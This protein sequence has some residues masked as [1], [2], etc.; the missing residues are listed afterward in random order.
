MSEYSIKIPRTSKVVVDWRVN[1]YEY[2]NDAK[3]EMIGKISE[4]YGI[5]RR[6]IKL[7]P[8]LIDNDNK[9]IGITSDIISNIQKPQFQVSLFEQYIKENGITDANFDLI[10]EIDSEINNHIDYK[11]YDNYCN[12][13]INW[14]KWSN[15]LSYGKD[16]FFDFRTLKGLV[17][18]SGKPGNQSGKSTFAI[19]LIH[20]LLFGKTKKAKNLSQVFNS[21]LTDETEC[22]VEGSLTIEGQEYIIRRVLTRPSSTRRTSKSKVTQKVTY[23]RVVGDSMEELEDVDVLN[24]ENNIKTNKAIKKIIGEEED[25]DLIICAN[26]KNLDGLITKTEGERGKLFSKWIGLLPIQEKCEIAK[27]TFNALSKTFKSNIYG[28][29]DLEKENEL[30]K[31][32][33]KTLCDEIKKCT[34]DV[35]KLEE[36]LLKLQ[37]EKDNIL[38]SKFQIDSTLENI[39]E[40]T[41]SKSIE[42]KRREINLIVNEINKKNEELVSCENVTYDSVY[43]SKIIKEYYDVSGELKALQ[44]LYKNTKEKIEEFKSQGKVCPTCHREY[45]EKEYSEI[46]QSFVTESEKLI[47]EGKA[48]RKANDTLENILAEQEKNKS[49]VDDKNKLKLALTALNANLELKNKE[50]ND[51]LEQEKRL[52]ANKDAIVKNT[53][54]TRKANGIGIQ[55]SSTIN[56]INTN[57]EVISSNKT[58]A[59]S[60]K[61]RLVLNETLIKEIEKEQILIRNWEIYLEMVGKNGISKMVLRKTLPIINL[62]LSSL[63][64]EAC[65]FTMEVTMNDKNEVLFTMIRDGVK[66]DL[67]SCGSGYEETVSALALRAVLAKIS[68]MPKPNML[69]IDELWG[70][71]ANENLDKIRGILDKMLKDYDFILEI[72]HLEQIKD[73]HDTSIVIEKENNISRIIVEGIKK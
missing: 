59:E 3:N 51:L 38:S 68:T 5:S 23:Y 30:I 69:L 52:N 32:N 6:K 2:S 54:L 44:T 72:T 53:E 8:V 41:L 39:D 46:M 49:L 73:W 11:V 67:S 62:N 70:Q 20:F 64:E 43:H 7:R 50:L 12:Y 27:K 15:F 36:Q 40:T 65:D 55:I 63:L 9:E 1:Q 48:K 17:L 19:E 45:S 66:S 24:E 4:K 60:L 14:I 18:L 56:E 57:R 42:N 37:N 47:K 61:E 58:K 16:N 26:T 21:Y 34:S 35:K 31:A 71:V 22:Y 25:F 13:S 28:K 10:K 33:G 29:Y